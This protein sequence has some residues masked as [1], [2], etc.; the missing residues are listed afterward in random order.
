MSAIHK[1]VVII[2]LCIVWPKANVALYI[3]IPVILALLIT[4]AL[5]IYFWYI[6]LQ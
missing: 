2:A 1:V 3:T 5:I 6:F 4:L